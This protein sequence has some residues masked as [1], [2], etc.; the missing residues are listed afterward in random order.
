M[1]TI[2]EIQGQHAEQIGQ[3]MSLLRASEAHKQ[4][5][6]QSSGHRSFGASPQVSAFASSTSGSL[7]AAVDV[8]AVPVIPNSGFPSDSRRWPSSCVSAPETVLHT[9]TT[10]PCSSNTLMG[11]ATSMGSQSDSATG[12]EQLLFQSPAIHHSS[13]PRSSYHPALNVDRQSPLGGDRRQSTQ[14]QATHSPTGSLQR[15]A[16]EALQ[17]LGNSQAMYQQDKILPMGSDSTPTGVF[18]APSRQIMVECLPFL[19]HYNI[20]APYV[21]FLIS[22]TRC[23]RAW[24]LCY[25][26]FFTQWSLDSQETHRGLPCAGT[27]PG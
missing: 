5:Y 22:D 11:N 23:E 1:S 2:K 15:H 12:M 20:T 19:Q 14:E 3:A 26:R 18:S 25:V 27:Q 10:L 4:R 6:P 7:M 9:A 17:P 24:R 21:P 8:F 13:S 16:V